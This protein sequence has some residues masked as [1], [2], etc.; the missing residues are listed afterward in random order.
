ME[1]ENE[2]TKSLQQIFGKNLVEVKTPRAR[3][4]FA[5]VEAGSFKKALPLL[6]SD[7]KLGHLMT[8]T[9]VDLGQDIELLYHFTRDG[10]TA[11]TVGFKVSKDNPSVE[12][13]VDLVP[14]A[15]LY[16]R[17]VHEMLGVD[18]EGH[19]GMMP[20]ILPEEWPEGVYPLRKDRKFEELREIGSKK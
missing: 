11:V 14:G 12:T 7:T 10:R 17:E 8:I 3:R 20:L 19:L 2:V 18:F 13:I 9:G 4:V 5:R 16:E 1:Q 15:V 6:L